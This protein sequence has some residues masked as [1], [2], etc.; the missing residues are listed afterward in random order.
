MKLLRMLSITTVVNSTHDLLTTQY[1][2]LPLYPGLQNNNNDVNNKTVILNTDY[3]NPTET[4]G[5]IEAGY[6]LTFRDRKSD[7]C[8]FEL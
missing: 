2:Y 1:N 4:V 5:K 3:V 8:K 6:K 7:S